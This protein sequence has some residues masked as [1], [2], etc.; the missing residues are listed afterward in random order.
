[1]FLHTGCNLNC[2][3]CIVQTYQGVRKRRSAQQIKKNLDDMFRH[4]DFVGIMNFGISEGFLGGHE[5][6]EVLKYVSARYADRFLEI[7]ITTNGTILP[8]Q[9]LI[10]VLKEVKASVTV[11]DYRENVALARENYPK[12][13]EILQKNNIRYSELKRVYWDQLDFNGGNELIETNEE[14]LSKKLGDCISMKGFIYI[15][16]HEQPNRIFSCCQQAINTYL[17]IVDEVDDDG[18]DLETASTIEVIEFLMGYTEKGYLSACTRCNGAFEGVEMTHIPVAV[19]I[20][21]EDHGC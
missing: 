6:E 2:R 7:G 9:S 21:E 16:Y 13:I 5:L 4:I 17:N 8:P 18:L 14:V 10:D 1:M 19:Q 3:G 15:G 12:V 20:E 11:D